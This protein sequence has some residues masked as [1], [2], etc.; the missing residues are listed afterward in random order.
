MPA[1]SER[2]SSCVATLGGKIYLFGGA[3]LGGSVS[4][5]SVYDVA[6][7]TWQALPSLPE[8]REHCVAG[9][10][11]DRLYVAAGR[12][13]GIGGF[14]PNTWAFDPI[15]LT[16]TARAPIPTPR[17]G[18]AGAVLGGKLYVLG[19]EGN[20]DDPSGVFDDIEAYDPVS[21]RWETLPPMLA[22]RHGLAAAALDGSIYLP[23]GASTEGFGAVDAYS[24]LSL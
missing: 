3:R 8:A 18:A 20:P 7:D 13:G 10:I 12:S 14:Q 17:G 2:A 6:S 16:Y 11:D 9:A 23:G 19:G 1:A 24:V 5:S 22:P 21:D 4:E 15:A